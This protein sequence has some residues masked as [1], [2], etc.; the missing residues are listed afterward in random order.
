MVAV[1][2]SESRVSS[3]NKGQF[4]FKE[5]HGEELLAEALATGRFRATTDATFC[6]GSAPVVIVTIGMDLDKYNNPKLQEFLDAFAHIVRSTPEDAFYVM[7]STLYPGSMKLL[8]EHLAKL[9]LHGK[10]FGKLAYCPER[11]AEMHALEEIVQLPQV[12][13]FGSCDFQKNEQNNGSSSFSL[14][15]I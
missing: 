6:C 9:S 12:Y 10:T 3:V 8:E 4:P 11:T 1:E 15:L 13:S 2:T 14:L 7:R 5:L